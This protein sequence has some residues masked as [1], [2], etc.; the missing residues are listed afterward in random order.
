MAQSNTAGNGRGS[1][2]EDFASA[3]EDEYVNPDTEDDETNDF[4]DRLEV[5]SRPSD[6]SENNRLVVLSQPDKST[7]PPQ[8]VDRVE[9]NEFAF[10]DERTTSHGRWIAVIEPLAERKQRS[11][12]STGESPI[13]VRGA[14]H[15][16]IT[17]GYVDVL[18]SHAKHVARSAI[19]YQHA[20]RQIEDNG[21]EV[22][23]EP[24]DVKTLALEAHD[25]HQTLS[26]VLLG[27]EGELTEVPDADEIITE[28]LLARPADA[29]HVRNLTDTLLADAADVAGTASLSRTDPVEGEEET[30]RN[31]E[32]Q[33]ANLVGH[34][35]IA[36]DA[37]T[38]FIGDNPAIESNDQ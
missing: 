5:V 28:N 27:Y 34:A 17:T 1:G 29:Q 13:R 3:L 15:A 8:F 30:A 24:F 9:N 38:S 23:E 7:P 32:Q 11:P 35:H 20:C 31:V 14:E 4:W 6:R 18:I 21:A 2:I 16:E 10:I 33:A 37:I 19:S 25:T 36:R 22:L 12:I 26:T